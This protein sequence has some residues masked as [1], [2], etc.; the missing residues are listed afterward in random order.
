M[1]STSASSSVIPTGIGDTEGY[2]SY[3]FDKKISHYMFICALL[4][5]L[6]SILI[7]SFNFPSRFS[8]CTCC[9]LT[10]R[11]FSESL[12]L[13]QEVG[14][15]CDILSHV[16]LSVSCSHVPSVSPRLTLSSALLWLYREI[17]PFLP[18]YCCNMLCI[19]QQSYVLHYRVAFES[20]SVTD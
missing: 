17:L 18:A 19:L 5:S 10:C 12:S 11:S 13:A 14:E 1:L 4:T 16:P 3:A 15:C 9:C 8:I 6:L 20:S 7:C 2:K